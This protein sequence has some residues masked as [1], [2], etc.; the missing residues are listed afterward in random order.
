VRTWLRLPLFQ[1]HLRTTSP[2]G[3]RQ[4]CATAPRQPSAIAASCIRTL[5]A[6]AWST[7]RGPEA[8]CPYRC[9]VEMLYEASFF[10]ST[11]HSAVENKNH[12]RT[13]IAWDYVP[14]LSAIQHR[15]SLVT[16]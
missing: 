11:S 6:L 10:L 3:A 12:G 5:A 9:I 14:N 2:A 4:P 8:M 16:N 13:F 7:H 1:N 15:C